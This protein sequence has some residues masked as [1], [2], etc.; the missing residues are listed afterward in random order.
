MHF[1]RMTKYLCAGALTFSLSNTPSFAAAMAH[2]LKLIATAD[3][4]DE[5]SRTQKEQQIKDFLS[6]SDVRDQLIKHGVSSGEASMRVAHLS[7]QE[8]NQLS[9][10]VQQAKAGGNI[11][12]A[13]LLIVLIIY[14]IKRI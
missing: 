5:V 8:L 12:V 4:V 7:E 6:R 2:D 1:S 13:I 9:T 3:V 11:L 10:Q 14:L